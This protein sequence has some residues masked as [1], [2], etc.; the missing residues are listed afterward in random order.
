MNPRTLLI[1]V[2]LLAASF[3]AVAA[4][5]RAAFL[6]LLDRPP[7]PLAAHAS[8]AAPVEASPD[9]VRIDFSFAS[10]VPQR[11]PGL[12]LKSAGRPGPRPVAISLH[13]TGGTKESQ[14]ALLTQ[15]AR[16]GFVAIAI[17]G[18]HH[19]ARSAAG[20][21]A[22]DYQ[23]AILRAFRAATAS[24][25]APREYPFFYDT[26]WDV[27]RLIDYLETRDDVDAS[28]IGLI[29]FS[30]GGIETYLAAAAD[31]RIAVAI[32]C[33]GV[34]SFH[35]A[36]SHEPA[37]R[38][39]IETI[40]SAFDAAA[41]DSNIATPDAAFVRTFY[42][43]VAPGLYSDFDGPAMLPLIAPRPLLVINGETDLRTPLPGLLE[44]TDAARAAYQ[45]AGADDHFVLPIQSQTG[46]T[47][48]PASLQL[49]RAWFAYWLKP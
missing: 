46:H 5:S 17:D 20:K 37:W 23:A 42:D 40:Q 33:I 7:V 39:R 3:P 34:Q 16:D 22:A 13:G 49:A 15:L 4:D 43:R 27:M 30:K 38:S 36:F 47:V 9:L 28:R 29:G 35:W 6:H 10:D 32:P 14:L 8:N 31:P 44:C 12:L 18:R 21:G 26:A 48:P 2:A 45:A 24:P 1:V 41:Q 25:D 11:V 19:G